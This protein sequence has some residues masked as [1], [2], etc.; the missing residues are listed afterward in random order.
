MTAYVSAY[1]PGEVRLT[2]RQLQVLRFMHDFFLQNQQLPP[3]DRICAHFDWASPNNAQEHINRI[4]VK[5]YLTKNVVG[6][7]MFTARALDEFNATQA[8]A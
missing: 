6:K 4:V 3:M 7:Y 8:T 5:G 2:V 1:R